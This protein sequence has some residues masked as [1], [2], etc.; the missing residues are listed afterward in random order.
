[1]T[2]QFF[3]VLTTMHTSLSTQFT[4][5][6]GSQSIAKIQR[7]GFPASENFLRSFLQKEHA[8][9][10]PYNYTANHILGAQQSP[11]GAHFPSSI[12]GSAHGTY[13]SHGNY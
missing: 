12:S 11:L 6:L 1:M 4:Q 8:P 9:R 3:P 10:L 2:T 7:E 13:Y 5:C